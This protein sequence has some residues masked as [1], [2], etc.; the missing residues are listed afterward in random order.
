MQFSSNIKRNQKGASI[1]YIFDVKVGGTKLEKNDTKMDLQ[2][3]R[4]RGR[5][6]TQQVAAHTNATAC[7]PPRPTALDRAPNSTDAHQ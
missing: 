3:G 1:W 4:S 6:K 5:I 7:T 2:F